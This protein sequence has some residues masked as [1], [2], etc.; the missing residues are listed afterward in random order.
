MDKL[1]FDV[2]EIRKDFPILKRKING[3]QLIYLDS[4]AS[5]QKPHAVINAISNF[6]ETGYSNIHRG[7]YDLSERATGAYENVRVKI[8]HFIGTVWFR[9]QLRTTTRPMV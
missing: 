1:R 8:A 3:K 4:A 6:Y 7:I 2:E 5:T 9:W